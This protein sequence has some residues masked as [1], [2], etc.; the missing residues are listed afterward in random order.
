M[1]QSLDEVGMKDFDARGGP[2]QRAKTLATCFSLAGRGCLQYSSFANLLGSAQRC[3]R[4]QNLS[5]RQSQQYAHRCS[6]AIA[7]AMSSSEKC[8][9]LPASSFAFFFFPFLFLFLFFFLSFV[10]LKKLI[11]VSVN[12]VKTARITLYLFRKNEKLALSAKMAWK[13]MKC[14]AQKAPAL[15]QN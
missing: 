11:R 3:T 1:F 2:V 10:F 4:Q 8:L 7:A 14:E 15:A 5:L 12:I 6:A 13:R 9:A